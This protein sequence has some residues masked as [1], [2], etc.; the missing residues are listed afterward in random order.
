MERH[1]RKTNDSKVAYFSME[2]ALEPAI[3]TYSGG[4][5]V[6]AGDYLRSAADLGVPIVA[7]TLIHRK[8]YFRQRLDA[9]GN[10][11][12][13]D[14]VWSPEKLLEDTGARTAVEIE[15]RQVQVRA[16][17]YAIRGIYGHEVS[18]YLLD[19]NL[20]ENTPWDRTITDR[21]YGGDVQ[22]RLCQEALLGI[23]GV[24]ILRELGYQEIE[25]YHMNEGHAALLA[26][27][28]L[29]ERLGTP[30]LARATEE[31]LE[32]VRSRCVFTTHTP[33]PAGHDHFSRKLM[34]Q[35]L[36]VQ[37]MRVLEVTHCCPEVFAVHQRGGH[38]PRRDITGNVSQLSHSRDHKRCAC[39]H[40]D[41]PG[42]S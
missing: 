33:V 17:R 15:G 7:V 5:G 20:K 28:L 30:E 21:L 10:Q 18:V 25:S 31:D 6:L 4:L 1:M 24:R 8:G 36:G 12:E 38:A 37:R 29:E 13:E 42:V 26:L 27:E 14:A 16:W 3:P 40:L 35:V 11:F 34:Q 22:Y 19:S 2:I 32:A 41:S 23:G 39:G 9:Q